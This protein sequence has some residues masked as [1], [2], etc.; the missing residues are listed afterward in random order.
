MELLEKNRSC[1]QLSYMEKA[2]NRADK[3]GSLNV[4][5]IYGVGGHLLDGIRSFH[6]DVNALVSLNKKLNKSYCVGV[7]VCD[8]T[9]SV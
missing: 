2:Y 8:V 6:K 9:M 7:G 4:Q 5:K 3:K 1:L